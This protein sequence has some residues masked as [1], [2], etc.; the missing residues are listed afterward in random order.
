MEISMSKYPSTRGNLPAEKLNTAAGHK[1]P[2]GNKSE[3]CQKL[4]GILSDSVRFWDSPNILSCWWASANNVRCAIFRLPHSSCQSLIIS[5]KYK[6]TSRNAE[7]VVILEMPVKTS[8]I[9]PAPS[10]FSQNSVCPKLSKQLII[11]QTV[12][13]TLHYVALNFV[14]IENVVPCLSLLSSGHCDSFRKESHKKLWLGREIHLTSK[15][16]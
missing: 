1:S 10:K 4:S 13:V 6:E 16:D 14:R 3:I 8:I 15:C 2:S 9:D 12:K 7:D 11:Q 5:R